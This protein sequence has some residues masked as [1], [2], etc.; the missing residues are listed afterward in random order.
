MSLK[1]SAPQSFA[2]YGIALLI[3]WFFFGLGLFVGKNYFLEAGSAPEA[4][5]DAPPPLP[6]VKPELD[7][8]EDLTEPS[9]QRQTALPIQT[10]EPVPQ[11]EP[12]HGNSVKKEMSEPVDRVPTSVPASP[13][14]RLYTIQLGALSKE[15]DAARLLKQLKTAG[16]DGRLLKPMSDRPLHRVQVGEF[17]TRAE[18]LELKL[19]LENDGFPNFITTSKPTPSP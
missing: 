15:S 18:A 12:A 5:V 17:A 13:A 11:S 19:R 7:F 3:I 1:L 9:S 2:L 16:Y 8:Y 6:D 10:P 14:K 4:L